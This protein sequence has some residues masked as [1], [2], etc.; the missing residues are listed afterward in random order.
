[1][2]RN[3]FNELILWKNSNNR[4]PLLL[5]GARQ[6]GKTYLINEFGKKE[7]SNYIYLN[8][9][10]DPDLKTL[11]T[12]SL[13]PKNIINNISLYIGR[14]ISSKKTLIFFDEIQVIPEALTSLK[15][16]YE[17]A[18][19]FHIIAAGSLLGVSVGR[20]SSFPVGKVNFMTLHSMSFVE[21]LMA[22]DEELLIKKLEKHQFI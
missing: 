15:Y 17:Q 8:F 10:Q 9:E 12:S 7:Y 4:K 5:Q 20:Q 13:S 18:P 22:F 2:K 14:K 16:F 11:F 21:Y 6:V 1:M 3:L 19:E